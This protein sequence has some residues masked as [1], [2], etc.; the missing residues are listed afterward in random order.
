MANICQRLNARGDVHYQKAQVYYND[1]TYQ[2]IRFVPDECRKFYS[3]KIVILPNKLPGVFR[4]AQLYGTVRQRAVEQ[5]NET[6]FQ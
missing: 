5:K 1:R 4:S 2:K 3:E 6:N